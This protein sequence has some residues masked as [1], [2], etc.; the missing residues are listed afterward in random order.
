MGVDKANHPLQIGVTGGIGS[1]K[2][3]VC[4]IFSCLQVPIYEADSRAHWLINH[5][6]AIRERVVALLGPEAYDAAGV[7]NRRYV[8]EQVFAQPD[9]LAAL[10]AIIHPIVRQDTAEWVQQQSGQPYIIKEAAI[11]KAAGDGN[12]LDFVVVVEA[13]E[14]LRVRRVLHRDARSEA[15]IKAIIARQTTELE[16]KQMADFVIHNDEVQALIPQVFHLHQLF[17]AKS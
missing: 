6:D 3:L 12:N 14:S 8:A 4:K 5:H 13:P 7:Y 17:L 9:K 11:M 15:E 16:R 10:N 1:G 2:S